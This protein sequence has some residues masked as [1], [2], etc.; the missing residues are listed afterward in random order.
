MSKEYVH[1]K[2]VEEVME[3]AIPDNLFTICSKCGYS[4]HFHWSALST[5]PNISFW[6]TKCKI[7][8]IV[9]TDKMKYE[10]FFD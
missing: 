2:S 4:N 5:I 9:K 8:G 1:Y 6:I 3:K 10:S 7:C